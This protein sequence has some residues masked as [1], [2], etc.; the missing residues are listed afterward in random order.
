MIKVAI[1]DDEIVM[2]SIIEEMLIDISKQNVIDVNTDVFYDGLTLE[3]CLLAGESYDII[4]LDIEMKM[5]DGIMTA[6]NIREIDQ[7]V[8]IV[9]VSGYEKYME[10]VFEVDAFDFLRKPIDNQRFK[11]CFIRAYKSICNCTGYFEF[12]YKNERIRVAIKDILLFESRGRKIMIHL[13]DNKEEVFN[14]K[15]DSVEEKIKGSKIPFLR[16][17]Q[18]YLVNYHFIRSFSKIHVKLISGEKFPISGERQK[19]IGKKYCNL[20]GDEVSD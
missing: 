16:I 4:Y 14:G 2:T 7:N 8:L 1:C 11:K 12:H 5:Q 13:T 19:E 6:R 3:K 18:S 17:H 9:Y 10:N 15:L 20:L